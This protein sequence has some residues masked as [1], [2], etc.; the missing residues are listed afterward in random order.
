[1]V[2]IIMTILAVAI[3]GPLLVAELLR[4]AGLTKKSPTFIQLTIY[5]VVL[6][7]LGGIVGVMW[8]KNEIAESNSATSAEN[9]ATFVVEEARK[10]RLSP[11]ELKAISA[12]E[13]VWGWDSGAPS[14]YQALK[15]HFASTVEFEPKV[16]GEHYITREEQVISAVSSGRGDIAATETAAL[17][18]LATKDC[19]G[20]L[21]DQDLIAFEQATNHFL[22]RVLEKHPNEAGSVCI[23]KG[24]LIRNMAYVGAKSNSVPKAVTQLESCKTLPNFNAVYLSRAKNAAEVYQANKGAAL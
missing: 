15:A 14:E 4:A 12:T 19:I 21:G 17:I 18:C 23:I 7:V 22:A 16:K 1:M 2:G 6:A 20:R 3:L 9:I 5:G 11:T 8:V 13:K 10:K 24:F